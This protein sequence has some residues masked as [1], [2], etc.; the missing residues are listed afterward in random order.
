MRYIWNKDKNLESIY[1]EGLKLTRTKRG[2]SLHWLFLLVKLSKEPKGFQSPTLHFIKA[3]NN[4]VWYIVT[5]FSREIIYNHCMKQIK[6]H[7]GEKK[8]QQ[9]PPPQLIFSRWVMPDQKTAQ[10]GS[11]A[12][13]YAQIHSL[14]LSFLS[15]PDFNVVYN[16][17]ADTWERTLC[18]GPG[19]VTPNHCLQLGCTS[20][21]PHWRY[22]TA[23]WTQSCAVCCRMTLLER[24]SG[25]RWPTAVP[26]NMTH[27]VILWSVPLSGYCLRWT[28]T[29][30]H[31][32]GQDCFFSLRLRVVQQFINL[33]IFSF[34]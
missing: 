12:R 21:I 13:N 8:K 16:T 31:L 3:Q 19:S 32:L 29:S 33:Y 22:S 24:G 10:C 23:L 9:T 14:L 28:V 30:W 7:P 25:S 11:E 27:S 5:L 15:S 18:V 34:G 17:C 6:E 4:I 26:F 1:V 2:K 20:R